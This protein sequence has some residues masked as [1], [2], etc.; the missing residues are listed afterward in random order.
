MGREE[1]TVSDP[2][3]VADPGSIALST[4]RQVAWD[5]VPADYE[6]SNGEKFLPAGTIVSEL[7]DGKVVPR[8]DGVEYAGDAVG[9]LRTSAHEGSRVA[10]LSGYGVVVGGVVFENLLPDHGQGAFD[11]WKGELH[12]AGP[13]FRF[14]T[15][16]DSR[17]D[18]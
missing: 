11:T 2:G 17:A 3:F 12:S 14:E 18:E 5:E 7:P 16:E 4:G 10:A 6:D 9:L 15:Y 8:K 1:F 13:G